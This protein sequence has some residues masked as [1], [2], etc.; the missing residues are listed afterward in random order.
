MNEQSALIEEPAP[1]GPPVTTAANDAA[2]VVAKPAEPVQ[3]ER[4]AF[5]IE[6]VPSG[7]AYRPGIIAQALALPAG[8][9]DHV[10]IVGAP[11]PIALA[12]RWRDLGEQSVY[13]VEHLGT[14]AVPPSARW[15]VVPL[16]VPL[17]TP[18]L[19]PT[20]STNVR[21]V[22]GNQRVELSG[23][24]KETPAGRV[25][26]AE[27]VR[28][29]ILHSIELTYPW[30]T[31]VGFGTWT[32]QGMGISARS[33]PNIALDVENCGT[34]VVR[35]HPVVPDD[36]RV[37]LA[38]VQTYD[39]RVFA[40]PGA[41]QIARMTNALAALNP[42][43]GAAYL[44]PGVA[45]VSRWPNK[46][47][48]GAPFV[49]FP[50]AADQIP[51]AVAMMPE[52]DP[53][54]GGGDAE[55][56]ATA[57]AFLWPAVGA[58]RV[59]AVKDLVGLALEW[60]RRP[61][62]W[63]LADGSQLPAKISDD[64]RPLLT[65]HFGEPWTRETKPSEIDDLGLGLPLNSTPMLTLEG[66]KVWDSQHRQRAPLTTAA[67]VTGRGDLIRACRSYALSDLFERSVSKDWIRNGW[68]QDGRSNGRQTIACAQSRSMFPDLA[69]AVDFVCGRLVN[70]VTDRR[71][72]VPNQ[73]SVS[74]AKVSVDYA[75]PYFVTYEVTMQAVSWWLLYA[76][77]GDYRY[78]EAAWRDS[79]AAVSGHR[80]NP[81]GSVDA[82]YR[83]RVFDGELAGCAWDDPAAVAA[84][85]N[86]GDRFHPNG[87]NIT[88]WASS[89]ARVF[90]AAQ[91]VLFDRKS[92]LYQFGQPLEDKARRIVEAD[93]RSTDLSFNAL[94]QGMRGGDFS[95]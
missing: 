90:L 8:L 14:D 73:R 47:F 18:V 13:L 19:F 60:L 59:R 9:P 52:A 30:R 88:C 91:R 41:N 28:D 66:R 23:A 5:A 53:N 33:V 50:G 94:H 3:P 89:S 43:E 78:L 44:W 86:E 79:R 1:V 81:N 31:S 85:P 20:I 61:A 40:D 72:P 49:R 69:P 75:W 29:G 17:P 84:F 2:T 27:F 42:T 35:V 46:R 58:P 62:H 57:T 21:A 63:R 32:M 93:D 71:A 54:P 68:V 24:W 70:L 34:Q 26:E 7:L 4:P 48:G 16:N 76:Q 83:V 55:A 10:S 38:T 65:M 74:L 92:G 22:V 36:A 82:G 64:V 87:G 11:G 15:Y 56:G 67:L 39:V 95:V 6:F 25:F 12:H 45:L 77:T 51:G 80:I 37:Q